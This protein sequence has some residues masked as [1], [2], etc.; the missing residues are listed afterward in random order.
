[1]KL[2]TFICLYPSPMKN[3]NIYSSNEIIIL[4]RISDTFICLYPSSNEIEYNT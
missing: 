4:F 3:T 2:T 1:M